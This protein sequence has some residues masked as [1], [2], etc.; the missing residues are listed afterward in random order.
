MPTVT[1]TTPHVS[2]FRP[3]RHRIFRWVWI[4]STISNFGGLI[5]GVGAAWMMVTLAA[6][7]SMVALV[8]A[9]RTLPVM[10]LSLAAGAIA[11]Q[12]DR[13]RVLIGAQWFLFLVSAGL[14][15][16]T[17][18]DVI[19]PWLL[20]TFTFLIGCGN[21]FN[22]PAWQSSV[23]EMVPREDLAG[24]VA[25]NSM[26]FNVARS[27]GPAVGGIIVA[28]AGAAAA[29]AFNVL[30]YLGLFAVLWRWRPDLPKQTLPRERLHHAMGAGL[31]YVA[32]SPHILVVLV[33]SALFGLGSIGVQA[34]LPLVAHDS[35]GGGSLTYGVLL[36]A[37]GIGAV[38]GA[39]TGSVA[40]RR[41]STETIVRLSS[42]AFA[43][44][45]AAVGLSAFLPLTLLALAVAG[46]AWVVALSS[47]NVVVQMA[48]PRWVAGRAL[49]LY[50]MAT[51]GGM[52]LGSWLWGVVAESHGIGR[53]LLI[54]AVVQ[55]AAVIVALPFRLAEVEDLDLAPLR[56]FAEPE[57][58][59]P[60]DARSGPV[61][62]TL[63]YTI[64]PADEVA[65]L[66]VM[67]E[68][69]RI[70]RRDG[71]RHWHLLRDLA[72]PTRWIERYHVPTWLDYVRHNQR[73]TRADAT[74]SEQLRRL[75][76]GD[77][78]PVVT[79]MLERDIGATLGDRLHGILPGLRQVHW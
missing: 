42:I 20:L 58:A 32:M 56:E 45:T 40:R 52:S 23:G 76:R 60:V 73:R 72:D 19:T 44:A 47:F 17:F 18:F 64:D 71:A 14:M 16:S 78:P 62:V 59:V 13:R 15:L 77:G 53:A 41:F 50:Q 63:E 21:A 12:Y 74:V 39:L 6:P 33:R 48:S 27:V 29:F 28:A 7:A 75:H 4:T 46:G 61:V 79:R 55:G 49:A 30:S 2:P 31:R 1:D 65:F 24:A 66:T 38:G 10:L 37:F 5:E 67:A 69:R 70:R 34:L 51:F 57:T 43:A 3:F 8:Q 11:D 68:R 36:G 35:L 25:L 9:S 54:A 22:R 26:G